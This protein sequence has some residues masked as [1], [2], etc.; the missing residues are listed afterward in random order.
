MH[1]LI[2]RE[3]R[4]PPPT[5]LIKYLFSGCLIWDI[6]QTP[7]LYLSNTSLSICLVV[8]WCWSRRVAESTYRLA[9]IHIYRHK[10]LYTYEVKV[11]LR[12]HGA[13]QVHVQLKHRILFP[14]CVRLFPVTCFALDSWKREIQLRPPPANPE[15]PSLQRDTAD[16][17]WLLET[18]SIGFLSQLPQGPLRMVNLLSENMDLLCDIVCY[19]QRDWERKIIN[20]TDK[21]K[22]VARK[23]VWKKKYRSLHMFWW[24]LG[25]LA[26]KRSCWK[27]VLSTSSGVSCLSMLSVDAE[28]A[29]LFSLTSVLL[30]PWF[31]K[32]NKSRVACLINRTH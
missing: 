25:W 6:P 15:V 22:N 11:L 30:S 16:V 7:L 31:L 24:L 1:N 4:A 19:F 20:M 28:C 2:E 17:L 32:Q 12:G 26:N 5:R 13:V 21:R 8:A 18:F 14:V 29:Y 3:T 23:K 27:D 9:I 10:Y